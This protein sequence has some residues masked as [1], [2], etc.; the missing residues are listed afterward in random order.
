MQFCGPIV[1]FVI[2]ALVGIG[3]EFGEV[4]RVVDF[5][6][7]IRIEESGK[8]NAFVQDLAPCLD[9]QMGQSHGRDQ[10][11][12]HARVH[13]SSQSYPHRYIDTIL[14]SHHKCSLKLVNVPSKLNYMMIQCYK[15]F[16]TV[17]NYL[18]YNTPS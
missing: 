4:Q 16:E 17:S 18:Y 7:P 11:I 10:V 12:A 14:V 8:V 13:D 3:V 2:A 6:K 15:S 1:L 9:R 5:A